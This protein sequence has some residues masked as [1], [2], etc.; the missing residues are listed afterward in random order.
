MCLD[1]HIIGAAA[2]EAVRQIP[3]SPALSRPWSLVRFLRLHG[4]PREGYVKNHK[5]VPAYSH[6]QMMWTPSVAYPC[7]HAPHA[8]ERHHR[9]QKPKERDI[10]LLSAVR[11]ARVRT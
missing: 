2:V 5:C 1:I 10:I 9:L 8:R 3:V 11:Y 6:N 4:A 7:A